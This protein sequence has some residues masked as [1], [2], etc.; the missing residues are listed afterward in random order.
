M[1]HYLTPIST[2]QSV[3]V[4]SV[5]IHYITPVSATLSTEDE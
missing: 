2:A 3:T 5:M 1:V 4:S